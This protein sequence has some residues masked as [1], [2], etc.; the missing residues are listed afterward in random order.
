MPQT[1]RAIA[2]SQSTGTT[3][4]SNRDY[5]NSSRGQFRDALWSEYQK[6]A[7]AITTLW[8]QGH[9]LADGTPFTEDM[10]DA[11]I[12]TRYLK[13]KE[14]LALYA[15]AKKERGGTARVM[16]SGDAQAAIDAMLSARGSEVSI[17]DKAEE[18]AEGAD[19]VKAKKE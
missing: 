2:K 4:Q 17:M 3:S 7:R 9:A 8:K 16:M 12:A 15:P 1:A 10:A 14:D 6:D 5:H 11:A 19:A 18:V 13:Y